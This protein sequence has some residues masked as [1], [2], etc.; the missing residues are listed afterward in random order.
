VQIQLGLLVSAV[1]FTGPKGIWGLTSR[2][3]GP[4]RPRTIY[5]SS[6]F[7]FTEFGKYWASEKK[8]RFRV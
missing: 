1:D 7:G 5:R 3:L 8:N 4:N 2:L 6:D